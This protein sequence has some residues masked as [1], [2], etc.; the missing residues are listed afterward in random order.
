MFGKKT[1]I[2]AFWIN[3]NTKRVTFARS[4]I[5]IH[6]AIYI[7]DVVGVTHSWKSILSL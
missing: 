1:E 2:N 5:E 3:G 7:P 4:G 6:G